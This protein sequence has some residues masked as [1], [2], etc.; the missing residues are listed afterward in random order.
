MH[1]HTPPRVVGMALSP[2]ASEGLESS[3][4]FR[5]WCV[6]A[7]GVLV[8]TDGLELQEERRDERNNSRACLLCRDRKAFR[9]L[10]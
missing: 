1:S 5:S 6:A 2:L 3:P 9:C 4:A 7:L 10:A 8:C